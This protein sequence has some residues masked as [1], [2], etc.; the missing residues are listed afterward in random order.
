[1]T[2][3]ATLSIALDKQ[4]DTPL[5]QQLQTQIEKLIQQNRLVVN[6]RLPS[7][8]ELANSL[9]VSRTTALT[10]LNNMIA[11]GSLITRPKRGVFVNHMSSL[12]IN[13]LEIPHKPSEKIL[14][15]HSFDSGAD[16]SAFPN[17]LWA[18]N[19]KTAWLK[20]DQK[21]MLGLHEHGLPELISQICHYLKQLRGLECS[22]SQIIVT[23]GNRDALSILSHALK[24]K[25][26]S[27]AGTHSMSNSNNTLN[28]NIYLEESC[29]PQIPAV[30]RWLNN[31][32]CPLMLDEHGAQLPN[33]KGTGLAV[34]TPCRQYPLGMA[35]SSQRR[36]E[37][38]SYLYKQQQNKRLFYVIEDDYDNE[39]IYQQKS[40][41]PLMQQDS[42]GS[43]IFVGS[44][45][46]VLFRGLR[47][48]FIVSPL[49]L[50]DKIKSSQQELGTA[51]ASA[52]QAALA[53]FMKTGNF[54]RHLRKMR[55]HYLR[56]RDF[57]LNALA[58]ETTLDRWYF[59][60][61]PNGGMHVCLYLKPEFQTHEAAIF[62]QAKVENLKLNTLSSHALDQQH[63]YGFVLGY[64]SP[65]E[66]QLVQNLQILERSTMAIMKG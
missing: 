24:A 50:I 33:K 46:K 20:P 14:E 58:S 49:A 12:T 4:N 53:N 25:S 15:P 34:L 17:K 2:S 61:K 9:G 41:V 43:V 57:F 31:T 42:S 6:D 48:G 59:W 1:M 54:V 45:S 8:R 35:M 39:F 32:Y 62:K 18:N 10:A 11:E 38:L 19:M 65:C 64:T 27:H 7:S 22:P 13:E 5:H 36:Q 44:F 40:I 23:A 30:F 55:R 66:H 52:M 51:G 28:N 47:L 26:N 29:F 56:K 3:S 21:L 60:Q 16:I 63:K 37:W